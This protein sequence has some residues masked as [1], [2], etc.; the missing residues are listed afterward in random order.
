MSIGLHVEIVDNCT[1]TN[2]LTLPIIVK[3]LKLPYHLALKL[4]QIESCFL[5]CHQVLLI[6]STQILDS[7]GYDELFFRQGIME[8]KLVVEFIK[9]YQFQF[10]V[11][12]NFQLSS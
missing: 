7:D 4:L 12:Q 6:Q 2:L 1:T 9:P 11:H 10:D 3:Y 8:I 5:I